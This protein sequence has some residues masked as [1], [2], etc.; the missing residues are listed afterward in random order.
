MQ[1]ECGSAHMR[2]HLLSPTRTKNPD[3]ENDRA[4]R[5]PEQAKDGEEPA[6]TDASNDRSRDEGSHAGE[7]VPHEVV[8][9]HALGGLFRHELGE[10]GGHHTENEHGSN[11]EEEVGDHLSV[12]SVTVIP[13]SP[14]LVAGNSHTGTS[15]NTPFSTV[16]PY[17]MRAAG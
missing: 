4:A 13:V 15:Q 10:H 6:I 8:Q 2:I 12:K 17:Q 9:G 7:N 3:E 14:I 1:V 5:E 16:Q 11:T